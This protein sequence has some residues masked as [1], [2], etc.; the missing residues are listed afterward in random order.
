M[1]GPLICSFNVPIKGLKNTHLEHGLYV[2]TYFQDLLY[3]MKVVLI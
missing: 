1:N 3:R 2:S